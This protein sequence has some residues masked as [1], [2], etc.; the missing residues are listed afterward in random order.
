MSVLVDVKTA[1]LEG[2]ALD[3]AVAIAEGWQP[4]RPAEGQLK[5]DGLIILV[6]THKPESM[7][8]FSYSPSTSWISGGPLI[9]KYMASIILEGSNWWAGF[10]AITQSMFGM[11][12]DGEEATGPTPLIAACRAIVASKL[13]DTV[14]VPA[15]LL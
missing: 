13:G 4:D 15:E 1:E 3:W 5:K 11:G 6:G 7:K 9:E 10:Q 12:F 14:S 8:R 2:K